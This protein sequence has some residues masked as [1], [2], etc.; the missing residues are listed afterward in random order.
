MFRIS[1]G[2]VATGALALSLTTAA[3]AL[4]QQVGGGVS[5]VGGVGGVSGVGNSRQR[6]PGDVDADVTGTTVDRGTP[7]RR[8]EPMPDPSVPKPAIGSQT[9]QGSGAIGGQSGLNGA[10]LS[11]AGANGLNGAGVNASGTASGTAGR[12]RT[13]QGAAANHPGY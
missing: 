7:I 8:A 11:G 1:I 4:A 13:G 10:G 2:I 5:G 12:T 6:I 3:P 9:A